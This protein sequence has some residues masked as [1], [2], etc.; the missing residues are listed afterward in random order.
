MNHFRVWL[1]CLIGLGLTGCHSSASQFGLGRKSAATESEAIA[2]A[3]EDKPVVDSTPPATKSLPPARGNSAALLAQGQNALQA[4][5]LEQ[6]EKHFQD[7]LQSDP[8]NA[9]AHHRLAVIADQRQDYAAA[10]NHYVRALEGNPKDANLLSDMGYSY[11]LQGKTEASMKLLKDALRVNPQHVQ[12]ANNL[13]VIYANAGNSEQA[14]AMFRKTGSE[15]EAQAKLAHV[16]T[17]N[18]QSQIAGMERAA[19]GPN[20]RASGLNAIPASN[21]QAN[22]EQASNLQNQLLQQMRQARL[23]S[24]AQREELAQQQRELAQ[25]EMDFAKRKQYEHNLEF[26]AIDVSAAQNELGQVEGEFAES[27]GSSRYENLPYDPQSLPLNVTEAS[28]NSYGQA[29]GPDDL[30]NGGPSQNGDYKP[31]RTVS[32][33]SSGGN[34]FSPRSRPGATPRRNSSPADSEVLDPNAVWPPEDSNQPTAAMNPN[35]NDQDSQA[36]Q[37]ETWP[38]LNR[39]RTNAARGQSGTYHQR[40]GNSSHN[41]QPNRQ[42]NADAILLAEGS[43]NELDRSQQFNGYA[44]GTEEHIRPVAA[45]ENQ[46]SA[47]PRQ[48]MQQD[49]HAG[50]DQTS[51]RKAAMLMGLNAGP[52]QLFPI[53]PDL[54]SQSGEVHESFPATQTRLGSEYE[55]PAQMMPADVEMQ[56]WPAQPGQRQGPRTNTRMGYQY[57]QPNQAQ[58]ASQ[59]RTDE[60]GYPTEDLR[61]A[62]DE[63]S[64]SERA[65]QNDFNDDRR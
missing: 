42:M 31:Y 34:E 20:A 63:P 64:P 24:Q 43:R 46:S 5:D 49:T 50:E 61:S 57:R 59:S 4:G 36:A 51:S 53:N 28:S 44:D 15:Q 12:A 60:A 1:G 52:S 29:Q 27:G 37:P 58:P 62:W 21:G 14:L 56:N 48:F 8:Q 38:G 41:N 65:L 40:A 22:S 11:L 45:F 3:T 32:P 33:P 2:T 35:F 7:L 26:P 55:R 23:E 47:N 19:K 16:L 39:S 10:E 17:K 25:Q 6:A 13:G 18:S 9:T 54:A 30:S